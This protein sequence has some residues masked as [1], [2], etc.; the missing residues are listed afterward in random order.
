[1]TRS[2]ADRRLAWA[3]ALVGLCGILLMLVG[4]RPP[5]AGAQL[6]GPGTTKS[7]T[8][9]G[10][11]ASSTTKAATTLAPTTTVRSVVPPTRPRSTVATTAPP[12]PTSTTV[13]SIS[14]GTAPPSTLPLATRPPSAHVAAI[15]PMLSVLGFLL[16][17]AMLALQWFLT[18]PGRSGK[19]L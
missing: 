18:K 2:P 7:A 12:P 11:T 13:A 6:I 14:P 8:T 10:S 5:S 15:F 1:V 3:S 17:V 16:V 9:T 19:T 4:L